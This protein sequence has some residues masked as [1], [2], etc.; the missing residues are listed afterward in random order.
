MSLKRRLEAIQE[1]DQRNYE[2]QARGS[3]LLEALNSD[4]RFAQQDSMPR[5]LANILQILEKDKLYQQIRD[6][7]NAIGLTIAP[8]A[9]FIEENGAFF[10]L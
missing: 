1:T 4:I 7:F 5:F 10:W 8:F 2:K 9:K 3:A 6:E